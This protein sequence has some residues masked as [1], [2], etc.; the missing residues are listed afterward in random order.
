MRIAFHSYQLNERGLEVALY[1][2]AHFSHKLFGVEPFIVSC[3]NRD[4]CGISKFQKE[5]PVHLYKSNWHSGDNKEIREELER[6]V[7]ENNI[8]IFYATKGGEN[9]GILP[10]NC[11]TLTHCVF[12]TR[13]PHGDVYAAISDWLANKHKPIPSVPMMVN[14]GPD[15][16]GNLKDQLGIPKDAFVFGRHGGQDSF[17]NLAGSYKAISDAL[18]K[19]SNLYFVFLNTKKF[20]NHPRCIHIPR[21]LDLRE[22]RKFLNTCDAMMH[23]RNGETFGL[24][25]GEFS[26]LNK[27]VVT[28]AGQQD[29][30]AHI[31]IL[32]DKGIYYHSYNDLLK[33]LLE[34]DHNTVYNKNWDA[35]SEKY[36]P[37]AVMK[38]FKKEFLDA[39]TNKR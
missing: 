5:F 32:G 30:Y 31:E 27:P 18:E 29:D 24:A 4:L 22:K 33:I 2:Y 7:D 1:D 10:T 21:I 6:F 13:D 17:H 37:E 35:Y 36:C 15:E 20:C 34:L 23:C 8:D 38:K 26:I 11:F 39:Y 19:R 12:D 3:A 9:D 14:L 28:F 25:C 16:Y